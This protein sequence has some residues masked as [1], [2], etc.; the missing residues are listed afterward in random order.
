MV[1][2]ALK[3]IKVATFRDRVKEGAVAP[4]KT[5]RLR[6]TKF[7]QKRG[8]DLMKR[9]ERIVLGLLFLAAILPNAALAGL[10]AQNVDF[11]SVREGVS[12]TKSVT[13]SNSTPGFHY[14]LDPSGAGAT[15][16]VAP[17]TCPSGAAS[18]T[19][20]SCQVQ[21]T[22]PGGTELGSGSDTA[23]IAYKLDDMPFQS[24]DAGLTISTLMISVTYTVIA[25][26]DSDVDSDV[27]GVPDTT[28]DLC[29]N[30]PAGESV[31]IT[32][33]SESQSLYD[34][35]A[36]AGANGKITPDGLRQTTEGG[37]LSYALTPDAGFT[38]SVGGTCGGS[39]SGNFY[40]TN[41]ITADCTVV[42]TFSATTVNIVATASVIKL[43]E[44]YIGLLGRAPDPAGL[45]YWVPEYDAAVVVST[46]PGIALK[47]IT[48]DFTLSTEWDGGLGANVTK[49]TVDGVTTL[50]YNKTQADAVVN[51]LYAN[52]F[53]KTSQS[54]AD[55]KY[56]SDQLQ[57]GSVTA[58]EM[59]VLLVLGA[60]TTDAAVLGFKTEA[61]SYYVETI[62]AEDFNRTEAKAAV[63][64]VEG[65]QGVA[66]SKAATDK[67]A[68]GEGN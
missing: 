8:E 14:L 15:V 23:S 54:D 58:S 10:S 21:V 19:V 60:G 28:P 38:A 53:E 57:D 30:T 37:R 33:C 40:T 35:T 68:S 63:D 39:L 56:W 65:S 42:A 25:I 9:A 64:A 61:A 59:V 66:T 41:S 20:G 49:T 16:T 17:G 45:A 5:L 22:V 48:N 6:S 36:T 47:K 13:V 11:G 34:V 18:G 55:V 4:T 26:A 32:G 27:D 1:K 52:L 44:A 46:D 62:A 50:S 24:D 7:V 67:I 12:V 43:T 3:S 29:P 31:D 2:I 51:G